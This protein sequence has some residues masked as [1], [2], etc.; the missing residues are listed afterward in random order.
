MDST[1]PIQIQRKTIPN[2]I[3]KM[4]TETTSNYDL[5]DPTSLL[6]YLASTPFAS[7]SVTSLSGGS[8]NYTFRLHL[9][10]EYEGRKTLV[11]KHAKPY[12]KVAKESAIDVVRQV[13]VVHRS[14]VV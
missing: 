2:D 10:D 5:S 8:A 4:T 14:T 12:V 9:K 1:T 3:C 13:S 7:T 11:L 6:S